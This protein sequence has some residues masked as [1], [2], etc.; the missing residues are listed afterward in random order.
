MFESFE[1]A[2]PDDFKE[3][4]IHPTALVAKSAQLGKGVFIGPGASIGPGVTLHDN[5]KVASYAIIDG[6]TTLGKGT[7]VSPFATVGS[8]PQDKT[9]AGQRTELVIGENN[10]IREYVNISIGTEKGGGRTTIGNNNLIMCYTHIAHDCHIANNCTF[11]NSVNLA[12]HVEVQD[13]V[14]FGGMSGAHQF[15]HFGKYGMIAAGSIVVQDAPPFC[16]VQGDHASIKGLNVV[17][18]RRAGLSTDDLANIK[19]MVKLLLHNNLTLDEALNRIGEDVPDS[20]HKT[21]FLEFL[22]N[23][24]R[25]ICR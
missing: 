18:L 1:T 14:T 25:G 5:V 6:I 10:K 7:E 2:R 9:F 20:V 17:G 4:T 22:K 16:L 21:I 15:C 19:R 3:V 23:S 11:A 13:N 8:T 12:G 24:K